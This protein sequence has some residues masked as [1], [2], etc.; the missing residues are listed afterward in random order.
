MS[1]DSDQLEVFGKVVVFLCAL[2]AVAVAMY[3]GRD[4]FKS[5][6]ALVVARSPAQTTWSDF[7][8]ADLPVLQEVL[9][10][11]ADAM[12]LRRDD[13]WRLRPSDS[14]ANI[15]QAAHPKGAGIDSF[16]FEFLYRDLD[17]HFGISVNDVGPNGPL[18]ELVRACISKRSTRIGVSF[19]VAS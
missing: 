5:P 13:I 12:M 2:A 1:T 7:V 14:P 10:L 6:R 16:E 4:N 9:C 17:R 11:V 19:T 15:Y 18:A 3:R 8:D